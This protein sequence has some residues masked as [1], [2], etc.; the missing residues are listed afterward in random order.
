[1]GDWQAGGVDVDQQQ[2]FFHALVGD[3]SV[4]DRPED[5]FEVVVEVG[6]DPLHPTHD[7]VEQAAFLGDAAED[8]EVE[9]IEL[10]PTTLSFHMLQPSPAAE[11]P[12]ES[13]QP[14]FHGFVA[15]ILAG[16]FA[17]DPLVP[18]NLFSSARQNA[19]GEH[20]QQVHTVDGL[21]HWLV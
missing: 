20:L 19:L 17:F 12:P 16:L 11:A 14:V 9:V 6:V 15:Q 21:T 10:A 2:E 5:D 3:L 4:V 18:R 7:Q 1:M 8:G 13:A